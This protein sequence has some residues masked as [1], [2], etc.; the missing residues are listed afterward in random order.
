MNYNIGP[1]QDTEIFENQSKLLSVINVNGLSSKE[2]S[3]KAFY[4]WRACIHSGLNVRITI[5]EGAPVSMGFCRHKLKNRFIDFEIECEDC[6]KWK[7]TRTPPKHVRTPTRKARIG[8][9]RRRSI[10]RR[11]EVSEMK[12]GTKKH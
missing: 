7:M 4:H 6:K 1:V 5:V 2:K 10:A 8:T 3:R 9:A 11:K 12:T